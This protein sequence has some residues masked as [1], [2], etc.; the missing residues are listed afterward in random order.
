MA[1]G[2][3]DRK[4][5][6]KQG[7]GTKRREPK[8]RASATAP[9]K[10]AFEIV[11]LNPGDDA[12]LAIGADGAR[13][14]IFVH[15]I[16]NKPVEETLKCQW[17]TALFGHPMGDRTRLAYWVNREYY[18]TPKD[19]TCRS[20]DH[21]RVDDDE[22]TTRA[23]MALARGERGDEEEAIA[24]EIEALADTSEQ[25]RTLQA[26]ADHLLKAGGNGLEA[27]S[28]AGVRIK[29]FPIEWIR[30]FITPKI[31][32]AFLRDVH[33]FLYVD[34][35]RQLMEQSLADRLAA[36]GGPFVVVGHSLGSVIAYDVLRRLDRE[37]F[38]IA[39]FLTIGSPLGIDEVQDRLKDLG[40]GKLEFPPCVDRWVNVADPLDVVAIDRK[41]SG[42][43]A[44]AIKD[45][46]GANPDSPEHPHSASGYLRM[47]PVQQAVREAVGVALA[48]LSRRSSSPAIWS[49]GSRA[50]ARSCGIRSWSNSPPTSP[51]PLWKV[52][53]SI[54]SRLRSRP[55]SATCCG[56]R[57]STSS[58]QRSIGCVDT[59][60]RA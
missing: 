7:S 54:R 28:E 1:R 41:L 8:K 59:C 25:K 4:T 42:E 44:G 39:L 57:R 55:R 60:Q 29:I 32:R 47:T 20:P 49:I 40:A 19:G 52:T 12:P 23:I 15:G 16:G 45:I 6:Q 35:R 56:G 21:V 3:A 53:I 38:P 10:P 46:R 26:I 43:F 27:P 48:K 24:N 22:V 5:A 31:T 30:R 14:V 18:P 11:S 34:R 33:D 36:G 58:R 13:T 37:R 50:A 2:K 9:G 51:M 17:D